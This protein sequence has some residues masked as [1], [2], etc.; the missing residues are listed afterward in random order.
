MTVF[1]VIYW[2]LRTQLEPSPQKVYRLSLI[3]SK[4]NYKHPQEFNLNQK[5]DKAAK[6][7]SQNS[8]FFPLTTSLPTF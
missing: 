4:Y 6:K 7:V 8:K 3:I 1:G 5:T 2:G